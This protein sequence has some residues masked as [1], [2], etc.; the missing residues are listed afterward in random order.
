MDIALA[1][2]LDQLIGSKLKEV[3]GAELTKIQNE[4]KAK[5]EAKIAE[6]R[7]E[8]EKIFAQKK[9]EA[10]A[11]VKDFETSI[12]GYLASVDAKEKELNDRLDKLKNGALEELGKGLF[13]KKK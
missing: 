12:S 9:Q 11:K 5:V 10:E 3:A 13:K 7:A 4:L 8:A 1:T 6:K 2:N